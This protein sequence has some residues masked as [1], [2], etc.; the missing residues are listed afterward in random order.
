[1]E[2]FFARLKQLRHILTRYDRLKSIFLTVVPFAS[3][4]IVVNA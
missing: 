1:M 3:T 2:C 4:I